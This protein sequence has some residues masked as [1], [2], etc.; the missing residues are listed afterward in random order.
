MSLLH[1]SF[2]VYCRP[3]PVFLGVQLSF[4]AT[5]FRAVSVYLHFP[6]EMHAVMHIFTCHKQGGIQ[7]RMGEVGPPRKRVGLFTEPY[8][9]LRC[10]TVILLCEASHTT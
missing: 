8:S 9:H 2:H 10:S 6:P 1:C 7:G 5:N 3:I 4:N